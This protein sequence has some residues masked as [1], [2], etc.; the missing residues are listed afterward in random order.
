MVAI[1]WNL[2]FA[3]IAVILILSVLIF[4]RRLPEVAGQAFRQVTKL[5]R[6]L[7]S[8]RRESGIDR[9]IFDVKQTF[10]DFAR[11]VEA[12]PT[13]TQPYP[14]NAGW[15]ERLEPSEGEEPLPH[16]EASDEDP[17]AAADADSDADADTSGD[18][19]TEDDV[20]PGIDPTAH[21]RP[22]ADPERPGGAS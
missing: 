9:E 12:E 2:S 22:S 4:G 6:H 7:D 14:G 5:R 10:T 18:A 16:P 1:I 19:E 15:R 8:L 3:E 17:T 11:D 20:I 13:A 21:K